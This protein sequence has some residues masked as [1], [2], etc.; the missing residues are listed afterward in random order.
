MNR[1]N[2]V[3]IVASVISFI[4]WFNK[5][6]V[7]YLHDTLGC[8]V[9]I[10]CN[11]DYMEDTDEERTKKYIGK[12]NKKG[13]ILHNIHFA[14]SPLSKDNIVAY[15][16]LKEIINN[17]DFNLIHCHTPTVSMLTRFAAKSA[18]KKGSIVMP[19]VS[20]SQFCSKEE[21]DNLL[22]NRKILLSLL[23][24]FSHN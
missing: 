10:A 19:W 11:F 1:K 8:E 18:R 12:L 13:I 4:E 22:P 2:E 15:K 23:R 20:V 6:N 7:D 21:L 16:D 9:H 17:Y 24:L 5:E 3:L 14:R